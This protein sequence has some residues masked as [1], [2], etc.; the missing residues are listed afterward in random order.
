MSYIFSLHLISRDKW[1]SE[2]FLILFI[3]SILY[4]IDS[5]KKHFNSLIQTN[6]YSFVSLI[7]YS[8]T[9]LMAFFRPLIVF[10]FNYIFRWLGTDS[11]QSSVSLIDGYRRGLNIVGN[12]YNNDNEIQIGKRWQHK[13][14]LFNWNLFYHL[15]I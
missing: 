11:N 7:Q 8:E 10:T 6:Y 5:H 4:W 2:T 3:H 15:F 14:W 13:Y 12:H 1:N 9:I